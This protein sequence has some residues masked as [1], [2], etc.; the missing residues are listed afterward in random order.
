MFLK[1]EVMKKGFFFLILSRLDLDGIPQ[2]S[3]EMPDIANCQLKSGPKGTRWF[4]LVKYLPL[5]FGLGHDSRVVKL[6]LMSGFL[7]SME[8]A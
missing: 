7:L 5:D 3:K 2:L 6:N 4:S 8:S 1:L